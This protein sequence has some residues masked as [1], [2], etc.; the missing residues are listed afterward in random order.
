MTGEKGIFA[1]QLKI[2]YD[3]DLVRDITLEVRPGRIVTL[4]GPNGCGKTT[5]LKT[6]TGELKKRG[7][8]VILDGEELASLKPKEIAEKMSLVMTYRVRSELMTCREV[9]ELGRYP[10][11]GTLGILSDHDRTIVREAMD[12]AEVTELADRFFQNISDGQKQRVMLARAVCQEPEILVLDEPTSFLDIRH[13]LDILNKVTALA[14][15]KQIAV[16]MSLHELEIAMRISD[17]VVALGEGRILK[18]GTPR[19]IFQEEF[20]RSLY[21]IEGMDTEL[22]GGEYWYGPGN[23]ED[24]AQRNAQAG[25][26]DDAQAACGN[27]SRAAAPALL[28]GSAAKRPRV[29]MIQ[30]TMSN[31]GKSLIVAGLCR[32][33]RQDGYRVAPFKSQNMA[34]NSYVTR[35]GLEMGRAQVMQAECAGIE[36]MVC[37]NPILLKPTDDKGSQLIV[38]GEVIGNMRAAEYFR[39]KA[40]YRQTILE[41]YE[42][43]SDM[44]DVILV[45]GAGSPVELNLKKDDIVNMGLA[46]MIDAP[47]LLVGD[48]DRGGIFAQLLGTLDLLEPD[49][50]DRVKG[51]LVNKFRGDRTLF[52][53]GVRILEERSGIRVDGVIPYLSLRLDDEDSLSERFEN[54]RVGSFDIA[55]IRFPHISNFTDLNMFDQL[56][57]VSV[58]YVSSPEDMK[59]PDLIVLPGSKNTIDDLKW[60]KEQAL[61]DRILE[62]EKK[63]RVI[64]GICG[65]YQMLGRRILD[66]SHAEAGGEEEGLGLLPVDTILGEEKI[67]RAYEGTIVH[68]EGILR[69]LEGLTAEGYEIHMG[70]TTPYEEA[71]EFT[72]GGTGYCRRNICG[73]Y[74]HG[75]FDKKE[76]A[77]AL[78]RAIAKERNKV[79]R[80]ED[81]Q[82]Y[83]VYRETCYDRLAGHLRQC[84]DLDHIRGIMGLKDDDR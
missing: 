78:I 25:S 19:E 3:R 12:W 65:G 69:S 84:L 41:A 64:F 27:P 21:R 30:G 22:L 57:E 71:A 67:R 35:E 36:P 10:Y 83:A 52:A 45:E 16:L 37:M 42:R 23:G 6:L 61:A 34:L 51:L 31:A 79:I 73:C 50:R 55:V 68:A 49:E 18:T 76:I 59:D 74:I 53:D 39:H 8:T 7:G 20:I 80:T 9:V 48:I 77:E 17:H 60:L 62:E 1:G 72:S 58:R 24:A 4:I 2:G 43:L 63:G 29:L 13:K 28:P 54:T 15:E 46:E 81:L 40:D 66:P 82:D 47:V 14:R 33:F 26:H 38:N 75:I 5:L 11:T 44:A 70:Q 56:P 32:I